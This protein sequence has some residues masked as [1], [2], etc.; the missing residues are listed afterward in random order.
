MDQRHRNAYASMIRRGPADVSHCSK[1]KYPFCRRELRREC[2]ASVASVLRQPFLVA[3]QSDR[4]LN[5]TVRSG[6]RETASQSCAGSST[7][8]R[9]L[10]SVVRLVHSHTSATS[11]L[12]NTL[13]G[14]FWRQRTW[15]KILSRC[16]Q[17][18]LPLRRN[19]SAFGL[20]LERP[21]ATVF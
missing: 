15:L 11:M 5:N 21:R 18:V 1:S 12:S 2:V 6:Q 8:A 19:A 13:S 10:A 17:V 3:N 4:H 9:M 14:G 16:D 20:I 7:C